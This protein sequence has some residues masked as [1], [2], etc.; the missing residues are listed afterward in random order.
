M[1]GGLFPNLNF[2]RAVKLAHGP[3]HGEL[4]GVAT[5]LFDAGDVKAIECLL[6]E[7]AILL[8]GGSAKLVRDELNGRQLLQSRKIARVVEREAS[9]AMQQRRRDIERGERTAARRAVAE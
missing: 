2:P 7:A 3:R 8:G 4:G 9:G 5:A 6:R 1:A